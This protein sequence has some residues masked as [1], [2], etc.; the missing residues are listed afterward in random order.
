MNI[1]QISIKHGLGVL[2]LIA[3][4]AAGCAPR[5]NAAPA[6]GAAD[7]SS[8][9]NEVL[10]KVRVEDQE[11]QAGSVT[12]EEVVSLGPG[13]LAIYTQEG[14]RL[15]RL[16]GYEQVK[17]GANKNL[18]VEVNAGDATEVLYAMLHVD[19]GM[20]GIFEF[21][22]PDRPALVGA[23]AL[24]PTF[25][26][27]AGASELAQAGGAGDVQT[28]TAGQTIPNTGGTPA[29]DSQTQV[30]TIQDQELIEGTVKAELVVSAEPGWLVLYNQSGR[31]SGEIIG[32]AAVEQGENR[33]ILVR[34]DVS[35][36]TD[37]LFAVL[38]VDA[39]EAGKPEFAYPDKPATDGER[40]ILATFMTKTV[41]TAGAG[42]PVPAPASISPSIVIEEQAIRGGTVKA[43]SV[44]SPVPGFFAIHNETP[45]GL[46][47]PIIGWTGV[48][49]GENKDV[50]VH[51]DVIDA[52]ETLYGIVHVD[53]D[54][55]GLLEF[56]GP[57]L[58]LMVDD[59]ML[60]QPFQVTGG[61]QGAYLTIKSTGGD[62]P[63]LVDGKWMSLY[64]FSEDTRGASSCTGEC[65]KSW[66]PVLAMGRL[67][68]G[69]GIATGRL[70]ILEHPNG[71]RQVT[72]SGLPLYYFIG[73]EKPGDTLGQ[74]LEGQWSLATP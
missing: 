1:L 3:I 5:K 44:S 64:T 47:G 68:P 28:G 54:T 42:E 31:E 16:I 61:L 60:V 48:G 43:V 70:G 38:H 74:G 8:E 73:D 33:D 22:G 69:E 67:I 20:I 65:Q 10:A 71:N 11:I 34:V 30:L 36:V 27:I 7:P 13:W 9:T 52:T 35:K 45:D 53:E 12:I 24:A 40:I 14:G 32:F 29:S 55:E 41:D 46:I 37:T 58:P 26:T 15:G 62:A 19:A 23:A 18:Q 2:L 17:H 66:L 25:E 56:P 59:Q 50:L 63:H 39:G 21:P 6:T 49:T 57:D 4:L 72:Y 51:I